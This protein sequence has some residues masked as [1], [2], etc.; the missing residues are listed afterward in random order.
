MRN[1]LTKDEIKG[2]KKSV[3][4]SLDEALKTHGGALFG[5]PTHPL[6]GLLK[7]AYPQ[8]TRNMEDKITGAVDKLKGGFKGGHLTENYF[9]TKG[10]RQMIYFSDSSSEEDEPYIP[11]KRGRGRP[12]KC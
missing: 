10:G 5:M 11:V 1:D 3:M 4:L 9:K 8:H 7:I 2:L 12:R 6:H